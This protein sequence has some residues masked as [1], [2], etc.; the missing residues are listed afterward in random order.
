MAR[1]FLTTFI[2]AHLQAALPDDK[3]R[4]LF[5]EIKDLIEYHRMSEILGIRELPEDLPDR[6][7][8][9]LKAY[10]ERLGI[11]R[12]VLASQST[13]NQS[14]I[15]VLEQETKPIKPSSL[16]VDRMAKVL[17][18]SREENNRLLILAGYPPQQPSRR[19]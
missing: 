9:V 7:G 16:L 14:H 11:K 6:F 8:P 5:E 12:S 13:V 3:D 4:Q 2:E 1:E 18:L 10:R 17:F 19:T 15:F